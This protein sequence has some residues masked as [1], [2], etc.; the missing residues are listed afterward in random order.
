M[1]IFIQF[2]L[3]IIATNSLRNLLL[4]ILFFTIA[5]LLQRFAHRLAGLFL[6]LNSYASERRR[7]RN[8]RIETLRGLVANA[9]SFI[10]FTL[11]T[12]LSLA[13]F[14]ETD[15]LVW[16]IGLF[17]AAFGLGARPLIS[18]YLTGVGF[19]FDDTID[20][21]EKVEILLGPQTIEGVIEEI[22]LRMTILRAAS[23]EHYT[24]PNGEIRIIRNFSRGRF[25]TCKIRLKIPTKELENAVDMLES[26][27]DEAL[28]I[29]PNLLEPWDV[30]SPDDE[31][32][33]QTELV[34]VAKTKFGQAAKA[35]PK[36]ISFIHKRLGETGL[37]LLE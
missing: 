35:R 2:I 12:V 17:S 24:I 26:L 10:A 29:L 25:S 16:M 30:F 5:W 1:E 13:L 3:N 21:G 22:W 15:T 20:V 23:G 8:E 7:W 18:D 14:I 32:S 11:A 36:I 9:I 4:I 28:A 37:E 6:G 31:S 34:V 27:G 19:I 33:S